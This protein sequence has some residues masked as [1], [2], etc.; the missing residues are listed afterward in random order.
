MKRNRKGGKISAA[1]RLPRNSLTPIYEN[2]EGERGWPARVGGRFMDAWPRESKH[3]SEK[4]S[5]LYR[6][7]G[8]SH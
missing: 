4:S 1:K 6:V 8:Q 7:A 2:Q 5:R 3:V